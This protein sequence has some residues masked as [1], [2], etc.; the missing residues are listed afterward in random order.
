MVMINP[1]HDIDIGK[2]FPQSIKAVIE[3]PKDSQIKYELDKETGL[4]KLDRFLYSAVHYPGDYGFVLR[5]LWDDGDPLDLIILTHHGVYPLTLANVR[6]IGIISMIDDGENDE[7]LIG[8][9]EDDPRFEEFQDLKDIPQHMLLELRH[10]FESYKEL[11]GKRAIIPNI[12]P[13]KD[14]YK[15]L[16]RA[17]KLY[18]EKFA[19][20]ILN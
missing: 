2:K 8:V 16:E 14:A 20:K 13:K 4:L 11:Q 17:Q 1:W 18:Q 15:A 6:V 12:L 7:K 9:Y 10:F 5:T 19:K 3:I